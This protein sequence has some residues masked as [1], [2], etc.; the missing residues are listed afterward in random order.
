MTRRHRIASDMISCLYSTTKHTLSYDKKVSIQQADVASYSTVTRE[1]CIAE[2]SPPKQP[3]SLSLQMRLAGISS[4]Q[5][6]GSTAPFCSSSESQ[7]T[8]DCH[9]SPWAGELM[10]TSSNFYFLNFFFYT[11]FWK[12][13][14]RMIPNLTTD[15]VNCYFH[16]CCCIL[17]V[18]LY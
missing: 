2:V 9:I 7:L 10:Q 14:F 11:D 15:S 13:W 4:E 6:R 16:V 8:K 12:I 17:R 18:K 1:S 5:H 3:H